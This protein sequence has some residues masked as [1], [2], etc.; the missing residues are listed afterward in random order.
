MPTRRRIFN[1]VGESNYQDALEN[2]RPGEQ[3]LLRREPTNQFDQNAIYVETLGGAKLG[4]LP[5]SDAAAISPVIGRATRVK[6]H[7]LKG[8]VPD[9]PSIGCEISIAW[10]NS[11]DHPHRELN[12]E[13]L[14]HFGPVPRQLPAPVQGGLI[15]VLKRFLRL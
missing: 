5:R 11:T 7:R 15:D 12:D 3:L 14:D 1:L 8:G 6:L 9:Y 13:Q 2:A 4:Y 10:D